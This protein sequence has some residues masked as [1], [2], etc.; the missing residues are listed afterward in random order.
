[1]PGLSGILLLLIRILWWICDFIRAG[2]LL[3]L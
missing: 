3:P 1:V 2:V